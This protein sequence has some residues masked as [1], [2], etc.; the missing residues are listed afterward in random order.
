MNIQYLIYLLLNQQHLGKE[1]VCVSK[2]IRTNLFRWKLSGTCSDLRRNMVVCKHLFNELILS[3]GVGVVMR[4][5]IA[6]PVVDL[7]DSFIH[8]SFLLYLICCF[9]VSCLMFWKYVSVR[10][11]LLLLLLRNLSGVLHMNI[12]SYIWK[13]MKN[14]LNYQI[15]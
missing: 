9:A 13:S 10:C 8:S 2:L 4:V 7:A 14:K 11:L 3:F 1:S 5:N 12:Q 15:S 6:L